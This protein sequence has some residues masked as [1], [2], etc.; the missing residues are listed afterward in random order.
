MTN[1]QLALLGICLRDPKTFDLALARGVT[2]DCFDAQEHAEIF[3]TMLGLEKEGKPVD[4]V[5]IAGAKPSLLETVKAIRVWA[6]VAQSAEPFIDELLNNRWRRQAMAALVEANR[7]L[8][9]SKPHEPV[10]RDRE[11]I[12]EALS[13]ILTTTSALASGPKKISTVLETE[14][15]RIEHDHESGLSRGI[16]TGIEVVDRITS[17]GLKRGSVNVFAARTGVGKTTLALN[18]AHNV[19]SKGYGVCYFTVEMPAGQLARK[20]LS[21]VGKIS[22][23]RVMSG[24]LSSDEFD[25]LWAAQKELYI[26]P[27]WIDDTFQA[28]F[29]AFEMSCRRLKRTSKLDMV[30]IDYI[31]QLSLAGRYFSKQQLITDV[32]HKVKQLALELDIAVLSL[33]QFNRDA[34]KD[35]GEPSIWQIKDSGAIEQDADL[36]VCLFKD[37]RDGFWLKFDKNRWGKDRKKFPID[38]DLSTNTFS[39]AKMFLTPEMF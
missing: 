37:D 38:A 36:G 16:P 35:G 29:E 8:A 5:S 18:I 1:A 31:Q 11:A 9:A 3:Q 14:L 20:L 27:L 23:S 6:P 25:K 30:V 12:T 34:E 2:V 7:V 15:P 28:S 33:A 21:M 39:N 4:L 26:S 13:K 24:E 19:A 17:G 10:E 22:G 32:S